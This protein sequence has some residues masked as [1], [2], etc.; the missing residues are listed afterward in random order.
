MSCKMECKVKHISEAE[1][2]AASKMNFNGRFNLFLKELDSLNQD[3]L[4]KSRSVSNSW[5]AK[6]FSWTQSGRHFSVRV[7]LVI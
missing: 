2:S 5:C 4:I 7:R 3:F 1:R 6:A